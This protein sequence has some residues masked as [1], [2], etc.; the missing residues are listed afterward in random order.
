MVWSIDYSKTMVSKG[1]PKGILRGMS[2]WEE[3]YREYPF[4]RIS[5]PRA[6]RAGV[7]LKT[8]IIRLWNTE[9]GFE[10]KNL[11]LTGNLLIKIYSLIGKFG[12]NGK[13]QF[14]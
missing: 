4:G 5:S 10:W 7:I 6:K 2:F 12:V 14:N 3:S 13:V 8:L 9:M 1:Y 11:V